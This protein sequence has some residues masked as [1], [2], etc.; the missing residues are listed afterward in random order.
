M[1]QFPGLRKALAFVGACALLGLWPAQ[2]TAAP[3]V[4]TDEVP[5]VDNDFNGD[6]KA[7]M[8]W[9]NADN[10]VAVIWLM[11]GTTRLTFGSIGEIDRVWQVIRVEDYNGDNKADITFRNIDTGGTVIWLMDGLSVIEKRL[12]AAPPAMWLLQ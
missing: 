9:R 7:D 1:F 12:V 5:W 8:L 2:V 10:G 4:D 6:G 3:P 11:D